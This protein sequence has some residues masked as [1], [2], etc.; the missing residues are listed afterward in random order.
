MPV[1]SVAVPVELPP[2]PAEVPE[3]PQPEAASA[4]EA[5]MPRTRAKKRARGKDRVGRG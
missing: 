4:A 5:G 2:V 3:A 1:E